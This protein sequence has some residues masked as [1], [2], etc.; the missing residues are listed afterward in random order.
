[1]DSISF[2]DISPTNP[3][4]GTKIIDAVIRK[5]KKKGAQPV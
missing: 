5:Y 3:Y 4:I 2:S 1:V